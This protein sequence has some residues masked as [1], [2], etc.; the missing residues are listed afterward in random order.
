M[1]RM[2]DAFEIS[3]ARKFLVNQGSGYD[4]NTRQIHAKLIAYVCLLYVR[5]A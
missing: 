1:D 3:E 4:P 2:N 5:T